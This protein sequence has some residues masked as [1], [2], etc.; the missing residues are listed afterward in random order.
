[1]TLPGWHEE[2]I[3]RKHGRKDFDCG[4]ADLNESNGSSGS[5]LT[6]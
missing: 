2:P 3:A 4:D 1:M 5:K 6:V